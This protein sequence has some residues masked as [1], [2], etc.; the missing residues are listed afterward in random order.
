L[1]S[2][3]GRIDGVV[4]D[5]RL[6]PAAGVQTVLIPVERRNHP[7]LYKEV[8]TDLSGRFSI[9]GVPPGGYKLFAWE[10]LEP[11]TYFDP[12]VLEKFE[13][14]GQPVHVSES[15][16]LTLDVRVIPGGNE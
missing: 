8:T 12:E 3:A 5:E 14:K 1:S 6:Q 4:K 16:H 9:S 10:D 7:E 15:S 2:K 11:Y 13:Q